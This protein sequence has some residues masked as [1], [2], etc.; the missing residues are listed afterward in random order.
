[1]FIFLCR[2]SIKKA[3]LREEVRELN[4]AVRVTGGNIATGMGVHVRSRPYSTVH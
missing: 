2:T 4:A 1:M 3:K